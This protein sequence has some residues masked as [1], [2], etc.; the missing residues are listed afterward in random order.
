MTIDLQ[1]D[2]PCM[3]EQ[4]RFFSNPPDLSFQKPDMLRVKEVMDPSP[5]IL[6]VLESRVSWAQQDLR[7]P[8]RADMG[9]S[10]AARKV[11]SKAA[12]STAGQN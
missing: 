9:I 3:L 1:V 8:G 5:K 6:I 4:L 2:Y 10:T 11:S 12:G 7:Q